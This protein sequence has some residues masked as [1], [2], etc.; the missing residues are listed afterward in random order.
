MFEYSFIESSG[1]TSSE[2]LKI[3]RKSFLKDLINYSMDSK[4]ALLLSIEDTIYAYHELI[5]AIQNEK[6][7]EQFLTANIRIL[8]SRLEE[9]EDCY[10]IV[11]NILGR[12]Y[13]IGDPV[14]EKRCLL[15][16]VR[17]LLFPPTQK[18]KFFVSLE[19]EKFGER[20]DTKCLTF[21]LHYTPYCLLDMNYSRRNSM[22]V[23]LEELNLN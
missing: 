23:I 7:R 2:I 19:E 16:L 17:K 4:R 5:D 21:N 10:C 20:Y 1:A 13:W 8:P 15:Y 11:G 18:C 12:D 22:R 6:F 14:S 3:S 9:N